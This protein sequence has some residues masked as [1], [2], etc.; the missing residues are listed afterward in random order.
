MS[1]VTKYVLGA[2]AALLLTAWQA[3]AVGASLDGAG[4]PTRPIAVKYSDLDL[5]RTADVR[6]LYQ[7]IRQAAQ[8][9]CGISEI[10]GSHLKLPSWQQCVAGAID[11]TVAQVDRPALTAYHRHYTAD[12]A[13]K[14]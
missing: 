1:Q 10:T 5:N 4:A 2:V 12:T 11:R 3:A 9:S 7:R 13:G 14:G 6:V 8:T